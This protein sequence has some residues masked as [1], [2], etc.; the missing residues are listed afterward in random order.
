MEDK[1][2]IILPVVIIIS[3]FGTLLITFS[4]IY[5]DNIA[6]VIADLNTV[7]VTNVTTQS[8]YNTGVPNNAT[9]AITN[10]S[11]GGSVA[12]GGTRTGRLLRNTP[13]LTCSR[14]IIYHNLSIS[15]PR[16]MELDASRDYVCNTS[17]QGEGKI[18]LRLHGNA[19]NGSRSYRFNATYTAA[20]FEGAWNLTMEQ[21]QALIEGAGQGGTYWS[22]LILAVILAVV[23]AYTG[24]Q[25][26]G[27][28]F[29]GG[30]G[31]GRGFDLSRIT[32]KFDRD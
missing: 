30:G 24:F 9:N 6:D 18:Y 31:E 19:T 23:L 3:V 29:G 28:S 25:I 20:L 27:G 14:L 8:T 5:R 21:E 1:Y 32:D 2:K 26:S 13:Q 15:G 12:S 17:V 7:T 16:I 11:A 22:L 4:D 10:S